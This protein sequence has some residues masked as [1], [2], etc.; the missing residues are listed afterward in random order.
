MPLPPPPPPPGLQQAREEL[1]LID[2]ADS[3]AA[4]DVV[5]AEEQAQ[6]DEEAEQAAAD[7][8]VETTLDLLPST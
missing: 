2:G 7:A 3:A 6:A 1:E 8:M 5:D 4:E